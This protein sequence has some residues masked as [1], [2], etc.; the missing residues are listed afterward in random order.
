MREASSNS[1]SIFTTRYERQEGIR[2]VKILLQKLKSPI[3]NINE[4]TMSLLNCITTYRQKKC[5]QD[6]MDEFTTWP[7][8]HYVWFS[9]LFRKRI[10]FII[11]KLSM[12]ET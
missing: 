6:E 10:I 9:G 1:L 8:K 7:V 4:L 3:L 2:I 11:Y 5:K 12:Q